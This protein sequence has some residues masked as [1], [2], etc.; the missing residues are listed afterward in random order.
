MLE[1]RLGIGVLEIAGLRGENA[2]GGLQARGRD[3]GLRA[4]DL[5]DLLEDVG[6][7]SHLQNLVLELL[8]QSFLN[9]VD[10]FLF[11]SGVVF[12]LRV[13]R[14]NQVI[15]VSLSFQAVDDVLQIEAIL[16]TMLLTLK[17]WGLLEIL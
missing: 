7:L 8:H 17:N 14:K 6:F 5:R 13:H 11:S 16:S 2:A 15:F 12:V 1:N 4:L 9:F 10:Y 3:G